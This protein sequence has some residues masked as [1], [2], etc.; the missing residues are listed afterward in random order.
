M[1]HEPIENE[2]SRKSKRY[3]TKYFEELGKLFGDSVET[4]RIDQDERSF[5]KQIQ[6]GLKK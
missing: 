3:R 5:E 4:H 1:K 6:D 2:F